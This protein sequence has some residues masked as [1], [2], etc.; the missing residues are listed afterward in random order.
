MV[1]EGDEA[2]PSLL[3]SGAFLHDVNAV[4]PSIRLKV[5]SNVILLCVFLYTAHKDFLH[6]QMGAW[7]R[8][9]LSRSTTQKKVY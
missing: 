1:I 7:L 8:G 3:P 6:C 9:V 5:V 4:D 2:E